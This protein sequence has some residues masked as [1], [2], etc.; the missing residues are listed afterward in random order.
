MKRCNGRFLS[1]LL[2]PPI[3]DQIHHRMDSCRNLDCAIPW[4]SILN[5]PKQRLCH[6][7]H[8]GDHPLTGMTLFFF[9]SPAFASL[10]FV[11]ISLFKWAQFQS[12]EPSSWHNFIFLPHSYLWITTLSVFRNILPNIGTCLGVLFHFW[13]YCFQKEVHKMFLSSKTTDT[14]VNQL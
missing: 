1:P 4:I 9:F 7:Y 8:L 14:T 13:M 3:K 10:V 6:L 12:A 5:G 11:G 2:S